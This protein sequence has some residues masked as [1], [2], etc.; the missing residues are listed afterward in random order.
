M[1]GYGKDMTALAS[2]AR[3]ASSA[4]GQV[5]RAA[6][7]L[8][9]A[10]PAAKPLHPRGSVVRGTLHRFGAE[11]RTG[12]AWLDQAGEDQVLVRQSRAVGLPAPLPDIFGLAIRV[13]AEGGGHGDLLFAS[14][15]Q[16]RL[17]R[18]TLTPGRSPYGRPLTTLLPYRT[19]AGAVLL[20]AV[21]RD[22]QTIALAWAIRSGTW[23]TF[24][25]LFLH[26]DP[27]D[28]G[29]AP[30]SFEPT[31]NSPPG[32]ETYE[33]VRRLRGPAYITARRSRRS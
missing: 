5:L 16:G 33:W 24:A 18:F 14:T 12:A 20:S 17:T 30:L 23:H 31:L 8:I 7:G 28:E 9:S 3:A 21:F 26:E 10:R 1:T 27:I 11:P 4:G 22:E 25:E 32:L 15:G 6:T 29:D 13:P 19:R 2:A